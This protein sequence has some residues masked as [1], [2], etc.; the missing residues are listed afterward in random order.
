M[1][2]ETKKYIHK[3]IA[4][5][6]FIA[7][8]IFGKTWAETDPKD[9]DNHLNYTVSGI[10]HDKKLEESSGLAI[11]SLNPNTLWSH[12]DSGNTPS[13]IAFDLQGNLKAEVVLQGITNV[14]W[15]DLATF[16]YLGVNYLIIADTGDNYARR[17]E[18]F[19][20]IIREPELGNNPSREAVNVSPEWSLAYTYED[21]ARD[22]E[23]IAVD[24]VNEKILLLS[25]RDELPLL[26]QLP[27]KKSS[28]NRKNSSQ[29][30]QQIA[31]KLGEIPSFP[32][33]TKPTLSLINLLG[34]ASQPTAMD[35]SADNRFIAVLTYDS[36]FVFE[37]NGRTDWHTILTSSPTR[38]ELPSSL[39]QAESLAFSPDG[40]HIYVTTEKLPAPIIQI[41]IK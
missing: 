18:Y 28:Y 39:K 19:L 32:E 6:V 15:E 36:A 10:I 29:Y 35:I 38:Y 34:Y 17:K 27:L 30:K 5:Y 25:K 40:N 13:L 14:D 3:I 41:E 9:N 23:S 24:M 4:L 1:T 22:C 2:L 21:G 37:T 20:H 16:K 31:T 12:N 26:F 7:L 8:L 33:P 11:S